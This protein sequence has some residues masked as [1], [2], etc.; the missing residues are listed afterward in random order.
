MPLPYNVE[1]IPSP[2][3]SQMTLALDHDSAKTQDE[4][5]AQTPGTVNTK[6]DHRDDD[7]QATGTDLERAS[8]QT[9]ANSSALSLRRRKQ[10]VPQVVSTFRKVGQILRTAHA[11]DFE[12]KRRPE[13]GKNANGDD[14]DDDDEEDDDE[15]LVEASREID[16]ALQSQGKVDDAGEESSESAGRQPRMD[17]RARVSEPGSDLETG[18]D[19]TQAATVDQVGRDD[20]DLSSRDNHM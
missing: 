13:V 16:E 14:D 10:S 2:T 18:S 6:H 11:Q 5:Q 20:R 4:R 9:A 15:D 7:G 3:P 17:R 12:R 19:A 8:L 1:K